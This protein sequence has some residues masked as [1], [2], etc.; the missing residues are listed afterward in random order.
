MIESIDVQNF[1]SYK[2]FVWAQNVVDQRGQAVSFRKLNILYGRNYS[3]KTTLSRI[4]QSIERG[5]LPEKYIGAR[6]RIKTANG[7]ITEAD[8]ANTNLSVRVFNKDFIDHNLSFLRDS[9]GSIQTFAILGEQN[10][11]LL[12]QI[13]SVE[14]ELGS[15]EEKTGFRF[16][17]YTN[18][19]LV[20]KAKKDYEQLQTQLDQ[21][22][23]EKANKPQSGIKHNPLFRDP[24]YDIRKIRL[25]I[26]AVLNPNF[27]ALDEG[28]VG[29]TIALLDESPMSD[30]GRPGGYRAGLREI[31]TKAKDL[32]GRQISP[33]APIKELLE[34]G[35][36]Q[37]WVKA[38]IDHHRNHRNDCAF[39]GTRF[40][41]ST[42]C[43]WNSPSTERL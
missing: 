27:V 16:E 29:V 4:V 6:F 30:I 39:S 9:L 37:S 8:V 36:L 24:N 10:A 21:K 32:V 19:Q 17:F 34:N 38:G 25:D 22:L 12:A 1:G 35:A 13:A 15:V 33:A 23:A 18:R 28:E 26:A 14:A 7:V 41:L 2:G 11:E 43:G 31:Y 40:P 42:T 20:E 3:G 5:R